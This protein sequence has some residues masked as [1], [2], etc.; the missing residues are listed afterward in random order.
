[1]PDSPK[2]FY[3]TTPIY[4]VNARPHIGHAYT[5]V[6]ADVI[7][8]RHRLL[9]DETFFL[10]GTDEHGQ[11]IERSAT[12]AGIP[13]QQFADGISA[14][15]R[16]LWDRMGITHDD[17][18]RTTEPRHKQGVQRLFQLLRDRG[19]IYL[20]TYTGQY[21]VSDEAY[22]DGPPGIR[23][24]DCG[25]T[26]ETVSE[27][28]F[29]FRLS[30]FQLPLLDLIESD[31]LRITPDSRRN[32]VLS[33]LRGNISPQPPPSPA[34]A[35]SSQPETLA[36][37]PSS[38]PDAPAST[39][40]SPPEASASTPSSPPEA[41]ASAP[42]SRPEAQPQW[43]DPRISPE[44]PTTSPGDPHAATHQTPGTPFMT[45]S[46]RGMGGTANTSPA[47]D[48][49]ARTAA[50]TPFVPGALKDLSISRTSFKWGIP[51]PG[52]E[53]HVIYVWLDALANYMT[54]I[55]YG[56]D[57]PA[58]IAKFERFWPAD[59]HLVG[60]EIIRFHC[61][62]W[63]AFLLALNPAYIDPTSVPGA[64][65][66]EQPY[67]DMGGVADFTRGREP[68]APP[69]RGFT[70]KGGV[71][72]EARPSSSDLATDTDAP[73][74][75]SGTWPFTPP[76]LSPEQHSA[77]AAKMLP[78]AITAHG[79]L[80]FEDS[81][82]SKSKGNIV[83]TETIL[84]AFGEHVYR[85]QFPDS[86][87]QEQDLFATDVLRYFLLREIPF[88]QDGSFSFDALIQRY[89]ADLANGYG[90][91][92]SRTLS[93]ISKYCQD[94]IPNTPDRLEPAYS[95]VVELT[96]L[97]G[98]ANETLASAFEKG[99]FGRVLFSVS[100]TVARTDAFLTG[101]TP[102]KTA[103]DSSRSAELATVL[104]TAAESIRIITALL[105]PI[106]PF[107]TARV[108]RQLG[109]DD[110][111]QAARNGGLKDLHWGGLQPGTKLGPLGPIFPRAEKGLAQTMADIESS[112]AVTQTTAQADPQTNTQTD[113]PEAPLASVAVT[114]SPSR[115]TTETTS[116]APVTQDDP[117]HPGAPPRTSAM[118][119]HDPIAQVAGS[120]SAH[121]QLHKTPSHTEVAPSGPFN[122][123]ASAQ[124][125]TSAAPANTTPQITID[126][127][128]KVELRV[129]RILV[130]ER[131]PKA[132][133][134]LR[135]VVDLGPETGMGQRQILSGIA[136]WYTPEDLIG[137]KIVVITN[138]APR[139]MRG[140]ES[141]GM[142]LAA[143]TGENGK[144]ALATFADSDNVEVGA[145]LK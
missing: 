47:P 125:I 111:E 61:V 35:P 23:C 39:P 58:D 82:M 46:H 56:S 134:L 105:Y 124:P 116:G 86:P 109:L 112:N 28:N 83:R 52:D 92:V 62:Y 79:W 115:L 7:A 121:T 106:L 72:G 68:G 3:L 22:V 1:M 80:L 71:S 40:S 94:T 119:E 130:C 16:G 78:K 95:D 102:W 81:K 103:L 49:L 75:E 145:R 10:T 136:E 113:F 37:T 63:P 143:S 48:P 30:A 8:R 88:G 126:D 89:N 43:R 25:R 42:S 51:V 9:G 29:Y 15:F 139:K 101:R 32:E 122:T 12:A 38:P 131:I 55:G 98:V 2:K 59:L 64:P 110:I 84:D 26:T 57:A 67:R 19:H 70:R 18:I 93:M 127:F 137:R 141:H 13:P 129:A 14:S 104:Y 100:T 85:K 120:A 41:P 133:K 77:W 66:M 17:F 135:L 34:S 31:Q 128:A 108:W 33:F 144:P 91:L 76:Q 36:S 96:G 138:L 53:A 50:G 118:P 97:P 132:D 117:T 73:P 99:D 11:K 140:L 107:A 6:V 142:L 44:P 123:P 54:A 114:P 27:S 21:C 20:S 90:N 65:S 87:K 5:T 4:Y 24:P 60:K 74:S 45:Q 69:S